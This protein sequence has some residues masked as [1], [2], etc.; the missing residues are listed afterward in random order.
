MKGSNG[1]NS[2]CYQTV[3]ETK[4]KEGGAHRE[5][6]EKTLDCTL[7]RDLT[8]E[9]EKRRTERKIKMRSKTQEWEGEAL[10]QAS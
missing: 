3:R 5:M 6:H 8:A 7:N 4:K 2:L 1:L 10:Q 9:K